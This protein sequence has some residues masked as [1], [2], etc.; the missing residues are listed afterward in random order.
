MIAIEFIPQE[1]VKKE[2]IRMN[3]FDQQHV[4]SLIERYGDDYEVSE[5]Y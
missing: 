3:I 5:C 4:R 1:T 2:N